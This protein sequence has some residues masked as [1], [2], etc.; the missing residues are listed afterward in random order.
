MPAADHNY[1]GPERRHLENAID[2]LEHSLASQNQVVSKL[3]IISENTTSSL[4]RL[5]NWVM[6]HEADYRAVR[7]RLLSQEIIGNSISQRLDKVTA[8][9]ESVSAKYMNDRSRVLGAWAAAG[10]AGAFVLGLLAVAKAF[11]VL[12]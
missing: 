3:V 11:G 9:F 7:E 1:H 8:A 5:E 6:T 2:E 4:Q 12:G 10:S